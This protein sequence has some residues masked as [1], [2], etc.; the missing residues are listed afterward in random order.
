MGTTSTMPRK[1]DSESIKKAAIINV[2]S[3]ATKVE[4]NS[5][6][7]TIDAN[8]LVR[9]PHFYQFEFVKNICEKAGL[10]NI[11]KAIVYESEEV[12]N[13]Y[14]KQRNVFAENG[15]CTEEI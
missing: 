9:F 8:S 14:E 6:C 2:G 13:R 11:S 3:F 7:S 5:T 10:A 15:T 1:D 12:L 4:I